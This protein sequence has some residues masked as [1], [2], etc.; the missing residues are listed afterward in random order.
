M[1]TVSHP[2]IVTAPARVLA[3]RDPVRRAAVVPRQPP[4]ENGIPAVVALRGDRGGQRGLVPGQGEGPHI[5]HLCQVMLWKTTC[6][7]LPTTLAAAGW[8]RS[9]L[10][11]T[12]AMK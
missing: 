4:A 2:Y 8:L 11:R 9:V 1:G 7:V 3:G 6:S 12:R 5:A 10:Y